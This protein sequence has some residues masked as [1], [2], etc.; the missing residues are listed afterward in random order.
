MR[1]RPP[2]IDVPAAQPCGQFLLAGQHSFIRE[3][4]RFEVLLEPS[5]DSLKVGA[6]HQGIAQGIAGLLGL[7]DC[8]ALRVAGPLIP[9]LDS[10][11]ARITWDRTKIAR[12]GKF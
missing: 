12:D 9:W 10:F 1:L 5:D 4:E 8:L 3:F 11:Q 7:D 2:G 6:V